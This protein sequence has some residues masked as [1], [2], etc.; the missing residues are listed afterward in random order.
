MTTKQTFLWK[1]AQVI[2][3]ILTR[4]L[5]DVKVEGRRNIPRR[6]GILIASNHQ[7]YLDPVVLAASLHRPL[8]FVAK[9]ELF[10]NPIGAWFMR[11]LNAFPLRQGKGDIGAL[12]ETIR[13]LKEGHMLN[14]FPEGARTPDGKI[15]TFERGVALIIRRANV[16]VV[17]AC[18]V[19]AYEA[20]PIN[21]PLWRASPVRLRFGPVLKLDGLNTDAEITAAIE[22]EVRR[23]FA[24]MQL[25]RSP[26]GC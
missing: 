25:C 3:Q 17:P 20:W 8:N 5:F 24:E 16:P 14:I 26:R 10:S 12:K 19:G 1:C 4:L 2:A 9:S 11:R 23:M 13:R 18:I 6:G 22:R 15:H 21:R 7:S